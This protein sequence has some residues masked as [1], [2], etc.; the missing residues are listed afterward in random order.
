MQIEKRTK[1]ENTPS[2]CPGYIIQAL[3]CCVW[4]MVCEL[5]HWTLHLEPALDKDQDYKTFM[6]FKILVHTIHMQIASFL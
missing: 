3:T 2:K 1:H 5:Q 6:D 4:S